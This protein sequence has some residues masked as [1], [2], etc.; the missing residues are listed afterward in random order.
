[1]KKEKQAFSKV[2]KAALVCLVVLVLVAG[3]TNIYIWMSPT[4]KQLG[5]PGTLSM[6]FDYSRYAGGAHGARFSGQLL[7]NLVAYVFMLAAVLLFVLSLV[8]IK[9]N[10]GVKV[11]CAILGLGVLI[12]AT[13][14]LT[15]GIINFIGEGIGTLLKLGGSSIA[16]LLALVIVTF[17]LDIV[18]LVLATICLVK[19]IKTAV[20]VNRGEL[21]AYEEEEE[22]CCCRHEETPEEKAEREERE[23]AQRVALLE[24]IRKVV[25]E[26]LEKL[27]K[28]VIAKSVPVVYVEAKNPTMVPKKE[29]PKPAPAPVKEEEEE[30][31]KKS[32]P[33][34]PFAEK[35]V[36][37]DKELQD[38]YNEIKNEI[39]AYGVNSRVSIA[40]DTFRLHRKAYVKIN[41]VGKT[42]KVYFALRPK[43]FVDSPIPVMDASDK[44]AYEEV[45]ALLKVKSNLSVKRA[46][47]LVR[48]AMEADGI[49]KENV[50]EE[51]NWI[52]DLRADLRS[53]K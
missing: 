46:K 6:L 36:K 10:K 2:S 33:R 41:I 7:S 29:E 31:K 39:L 32:A 19:G 20:K 48:L 3:W 1:M 37:A 5:F 15:G 4:L 47:E 11:K 51:H 49:A 40:C 35:M 9:H 38:K 42:L 22:S 45:P 52:R 53:K 8:L 21:P 34:I 26:E 30:S 23:A 16:A 27:D 43:D 25:K 18:Y 28:V 13:F 17:L 14:G 44:V 50:A 24:D 12:P